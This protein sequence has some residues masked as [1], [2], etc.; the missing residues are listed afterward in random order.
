M[1]IDCDWK[2][3]SKLAKFHM[4]RFALHAVLS[5]ASKTLTRKWGAI[6]GCEK[7]IFSGLISRHLPETKITT[8]STD[9]VRH[10]ILDRNWSQKQH[11]VESLRHW[12]S[13]RGPGILAPTVYVKFKVFW[14][15][16][17]S[18]RMSWH[19]RETGNFEADDY[20][21]NARF[22][23]LSGIL[24]TRSCVPFRQTGKFQ[25]GR[26]PWMKLCSRRG[27]VFIWWSTGLLA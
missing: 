23:W 13:S 5:L 18:E 1:A 2:L 10:F 21:D 17:C 4:C 19:W 26:I 12:P 22:R 9:T 7:R 20:I 15:Q 14:A 24:V 3:K 27:S 16:C 6:R 11:L 25:A 8:S